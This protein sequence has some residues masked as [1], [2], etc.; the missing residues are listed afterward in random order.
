[1]SSVRRGNLMNY[2]IFDLEF[3]QDL[4]SIQD[5]SRITSKNPFEIIQIG[6]IKLDD[7]FNTIGT[8]DRLVKP[9]IYSKISLFISELT[10]ITTEV[11]LTEELFPEVY[12]DYLEFIGETDTTFCIW[13]MSDIKE[14]Y[15]NAEYHRLQ[16][17]SLPTKYINLQPYTSI[18]LD[19]PLNMLPRL[20]VATEELDIPL[21]YKFHNAFYD[22][23]YTA[24]IFKKIYSPSMQTKIYDP[25]YVSIRPRQPRKI[26]DTEKL[27]MQFEKMYDRDMTEEEQEIILLAYKIG[28]SNQFLI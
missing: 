19:Y 5:V 2:I 21:T 3:N 8:F 17:K 26:I 11:L 12:R 15:K 22:A 23:Y 6:A 9:S 1:M 27:I 16:Y 18:Y 25:T 28:K 20:Q 13:G 10:G 7:N 14:L 24:E 4:T